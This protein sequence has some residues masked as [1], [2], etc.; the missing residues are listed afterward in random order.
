MTDIIQGYS[1]AVAGLYTARIASFFA[2]IECTFERA[3]NEK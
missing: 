2:D 1:R 3:L